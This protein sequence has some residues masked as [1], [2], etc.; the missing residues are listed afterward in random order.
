MS[1]TRDRFCFAD[2][3]LSSASR[4]FVLNRVIPA[5]SSMIDRRS[6]GFELSNCP[7]RSCP[8][9]AYVSPPSPV[10]MKM[11]WISRSRQIF[12]F[13]RYSLSPVRN[14]RRVIVSSPARTGAR[15]NFLRRIFN[16]TLFGLVPLFALSMPA[17]SAS[18]CA[19]ASVAAAIASPSSTVPGCA[20]ATASSVSVARC[21]RSDVS[22]Q[23]LIP[24]SIATTSD[25]SGSPAPSY[26]SGSTSVSDTSAI[27]VALRSRVPAK[28]TSSILIPR[29]LLADC[30]PST[31]VIASEMFDFPHPFGPTIAAI[32]SPAS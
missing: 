8:M 7:I 32:P 19:A 23:S 22:S 28:I 13:S 21:C 24:L 1:F 16:T 18:T 3:S 10:P 9:I 31:H 5:A 12:P 29:R 6:S 30:S 14:S 15:P 2:S 11:S 17:A 25:S 26:T 4:F 20:S 27:P